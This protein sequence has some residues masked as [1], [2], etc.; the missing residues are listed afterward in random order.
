MS[1]PLPDAMVA[2]QNST[3][4]IP[5]IY[6]ADPQ[7]THQALIANIDD[8]FSTSR[9]RL[10]RIAQAYG[11]PSDAADD[12]VQ[13]TLLEAW[14]HLDHLRAPERFEAWLKGICRNVCLRW[15]RAQGVVTTRQVPLSH[16][17]VLQ[18]SGEEAGVEE[19]IPDPTIFDPAEELSHP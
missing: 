2:I 1:G 5:H 8:L 18:V 10:L 15:S 4:S 12:I 13:E 7:G 11:A 9:P 3:H 16:L 17:Y 6:E 19:A 14:Q